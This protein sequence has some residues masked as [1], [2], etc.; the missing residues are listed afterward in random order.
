LLFDVPHIKPAGLPAL[1]RDRIMLEAAE[2]ARGVN[3]VQQRDRKRMNVALDKTMTG[4]RAAGAVA[5][6]SR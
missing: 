5:N 2:D 3:E 4:R 6:I 1:E